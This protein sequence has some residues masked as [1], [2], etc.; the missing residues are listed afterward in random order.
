MSVASILLPLFVQVVLTLVLGF[1]LAGARMK[2]LVRG[3]IRPEQVALRQPNWPT[4]TLQIGYAFQNQFEVPVLFY[5]L[6]ILALVT[7][8][9]DLL[10]VVLAWIFVASRLVHAFVHVTSNNLRA[11]GGF[12]G[13]GVLVI[14]IMWLIFIVKIM[15]GLP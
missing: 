7:R 6:T 8:H 10:F 15:L 4:R 2:P 9:A 3:E 13:I 1:M 5:V 11:R 14:A 12:F